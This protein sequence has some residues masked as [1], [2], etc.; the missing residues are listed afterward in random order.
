MTRHLILGSS[1]KPRRMLLERF[2]IPFDIAHPDVDETPLPDESPSQM[3]LRLAEIKARTV[4]EKYPNDIIIGADQVGVL[5]NEILGKPLSFENAIQQLQ[6][7]SQKH[8]QFYIGLCVLDAK[9]Q[10]QEVVLETFD[11]KFRQLDLPMIENY[12]RKDQPLQCAGSFKAEGLGI[13][14][15]DEFFGK[16]F[17]A[18]IGLPLIRLTRMLENAGI[19]PLGT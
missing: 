11:V 15:V 2:Q 18:L 9:K 7:M 10:T 19:Y 12:L 8:V 4:A 5:E 1:S 17:T 14:L 6:K 16:D 13:A 3:V